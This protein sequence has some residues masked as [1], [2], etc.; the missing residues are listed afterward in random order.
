[1]IITSYDC[2]IK[3][4][5]VVS[6]DFDELWKDKINNEIDKLETLYIN[7]DSYNKVEFLKEIII[8]LK[9]IDNILDNIIKIKFLNVINLIGDK[10]IN[11]SD[12]YERTIRTKNIL[13][14]I[15]KYTG[16]PDVV[17]V[18]YQMKPNDKSRC[19]SHQI[20]YHYSN[21]T[22]EKIIC[23]VPEYNL[24]DIVS[25]EQYNTKVYEVGT[26]LKNKYS[27][28]KKGEYSNFIEKYSNYVANKKHTDC[29]FKYYTRVFGIKFSIDKKNKTNDIADAFM[30]AF[31]WLKK[32]NYL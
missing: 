29:N 20:I 16:V 31:G 1:M 14:K 2:A 9:S 4:L 13:H 15:D 5:G 11:N 7:S 28:F 3:N 24:N 30:M 6:I 8:I 27:L 17:L 12:I 18:E 22:N 32:N 23:S 25:N 10:K 26:T 19:M 21:N